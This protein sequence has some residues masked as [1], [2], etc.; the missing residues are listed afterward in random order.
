MAQ[1]VLD[2]AYPLDDMAESLFGKGKRP[3]VMPVAACPG[4]EAQMV[5]NDRRLQAGDEIAQLTQ[6]GFVQWRDGP[7]RQ[8]NTVKHDWYF[9][10]KPVQHGPRSS[11]TTKEVLRDGL[12][13][14][15]PPNALLEEH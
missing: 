11:P 14:I 9:P 10:A 4:A 3:E 7:Y 13:D 12:D 8:G 2:P 6:I 15:H 5:G 1:V